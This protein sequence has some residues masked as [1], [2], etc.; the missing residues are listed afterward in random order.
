MTNQTIIRDIIN[1]TEPEPN[2]YFA[3]WRVNYGPHMT[4]H[5]DYQSFYEANEFARERAESHNEFTEVVDILR[6]RTINIY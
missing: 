6:N 1:T 3:P 5:C 4:K 2:L